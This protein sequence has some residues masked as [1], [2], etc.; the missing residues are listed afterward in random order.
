[1][2]PIALLPQF[3]VLLLALG[4]LFGE[5]SIQAQTQAEIQAAKI[6][7]Q[8]ILKEQRILQDRRHDLRFES[9]L[10]NNKTTIVAYNPNHS[11]NPKVIQASLQTLCQHKTQASRVLALYL[12]GD[13][14][15]CGPG[16]MSQSIKVDYG[17]QPDSMK[18]EMQRIYTVKTMLDLQKLK[19][20]W[21]LLG[22]NNP[23]ERAYGLTALYKAAEAEDLPPD[24]RQKL[25]DYESALNDEINP[26]SGCKS[27]DSDAT[28]NITDFIQFLQTRYAPGA[29]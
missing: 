18:A 16:D 17:S 3:S 27:A 5:Q 29:T 9:D 1:M 12:R 22:V 8:V 14:T 24:L 10:A 4:M 25:I 11:D 19:T 28:T 6:Q 26:K 15:G 13:P 20:D 21:V 2:K 23:L 7:L